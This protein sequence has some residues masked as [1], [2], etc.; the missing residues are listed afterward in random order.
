ML[1]AM[2]N[3]LALTGLPE[4]SKAVYRKVIELDSGNKDALDNIKLIEEA[5]KKERQISE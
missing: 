5:Q 4:E 2:G 3:S 1:L